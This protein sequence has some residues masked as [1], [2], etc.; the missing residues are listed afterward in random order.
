[1]YALRRWWDRNGIRLGLIALVLGGAWAIRQTQGAFVFEIYRALAQPFGSQAAK[2]DPIADA[3]TQELQQRVTELESQNRQLQ[4]LLGYVKQS[5]K[6][7]V[8]SPVIGRSADHWWQLITIGRGSQ[9]GIKVGSIASGNGGVVGRVVQ[10]T[11]HTSRVLLI[12]DPTSQAGVVISRSRNMGYIRGQAANRVVMEFFDKVP[13][14][15]SGDVVATSSYSQLFPA[16]LPI[17]VVESV[18]LNKSPAPEAVVALSAPISHLEWVVVYP[19][20]KTGAADLTEEELLQ[21]SQKNNPL[22]RITP[23]TENS[24]SESEGSNF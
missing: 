24:G 8:V 13:D 6:Q 1:M 19:N 23:Q 4:E 18:N 5:P 2:T 11:D 14:V 7:G 20:P 17:G 9:D 21:E 12:S 22:N 16:G 10:V 3:R 15:R